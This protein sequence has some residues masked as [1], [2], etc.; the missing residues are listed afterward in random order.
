MIAEEVGQYAR[1]MDYPKM[2]PLLVEALNA[3]RAEKDAEIGELKGE[4]AELRELVDQLVA[5]PH[6][7]TA[8]E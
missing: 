4:I 2:A 6:A 8:G 5:A 1:G 7:A 3:L